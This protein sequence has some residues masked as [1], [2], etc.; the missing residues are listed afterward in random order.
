VPWATLLYNSRKKSQEPLRRRLHSA[1]DDRSPAVFAALHGVTTEHFAQGE[2]D[3]TN[4][5]PRQVF[6][7][8]ADTA[9]DPALRL[10]DDIHDQGEALFASL[11][12]AGAQSECSQR[13]FTFSSRYFIF[14][15]CAREGLS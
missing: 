15:C 11:A 6:A 4:S 12:A 5:E 7:A 8:P 1:L 13:S 2:P 9:L 3:K 14:L 10:S